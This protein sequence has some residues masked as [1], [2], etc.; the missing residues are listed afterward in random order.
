MHWLLIACAAAI[1]AASI[2]VGALVAGRAGAATCVRY[3]VLGL[4]KIA[5]R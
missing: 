4:V 3:G 1:Y 2:G 5:R